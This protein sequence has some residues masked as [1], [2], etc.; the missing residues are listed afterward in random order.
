MLHS[1]SLMQMRFIP[2]DKRVCWIIG[3][4]ISTLCFSNL[5]AGQFSGSLAVTSDYVYRGISQTRGA[6]AAQGSIQ[7]ATLDHW[8]MGIWA[9]TT[10]LNTYDGTTAE[11]D[12]Y[13]S[14]RWNISDAWHG[15]FSALRYLYPLNSNTAHYEYDEVAASVD[16]GD[17][18][19]FNV[20]WS[21][22]ASRYSAWR[23]VKGNAI[24]YE[25]SWMRPLPKLFSLNAGIGYYDL[26]DIMNTGYWYWNAGAGKDWRMW[27]VALSYIGTSQKAEQAFG[28]A[29][30]GNRFSITLLRRF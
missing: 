4:L 17:M 14:F 23:Y 5:Y 24:S 11:V 30:T 22:D 9:S 20:A 8:A 6:A 12:P 1:T 18:L 28:T 7:Y 29:S 10:E 13:I 19:F 25:A 2:I 26:S 15:K 27:H 21:W 3:L 16:Y